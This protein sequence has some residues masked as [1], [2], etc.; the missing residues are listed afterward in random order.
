MKLQ[1]SYFGTVF[2]F[3]YWYFFEKHR[4]LFFTVDL[5]GVFISLR[6][7]HQVRDHLQILSELKRTNKLLFLRKS[8]VNVWFSD[9][10]RGI[11]VGCTWICLILEANFGVHFFSAKLAE[12]NLVYNGQPISAKSNTYQRHDTLP[13]QSHSKCWHVDRTKI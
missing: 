1:T 9:D 8:S 3:L 12:K 11:D 2:K 4:L 13:G 5:F 10:F 7:W 6:F